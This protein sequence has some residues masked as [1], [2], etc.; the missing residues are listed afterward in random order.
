MVILEETGRITVVVSVGMSIFTLVAVALRF[1]AKWKGNVPHRLEDILIVLALATFAAYVGCFLKGILRVLSSDAAQVIAIDC[2][3]AL[4]SAGGTLD[5]S[6][7][8]L[9]ELEAVFFV[10]KPRSEVTVNKD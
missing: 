1:V 4:L 5:E 6:Q 9:P 2:H 7:L 3:I 10:S 8:Q